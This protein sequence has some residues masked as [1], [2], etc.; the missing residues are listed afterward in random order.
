MLAQG[1]ALAVAL[2]AA[3]V[4]LHAGLGER[5][6]GGTQAGAGVG[7]E[8]LLHEGVQCALQIAQRDAF[9]HDQTFHLVEHGAVSSVRVRAEHAAGDQHLDGRLLA[10][11]SADL[12]TGG[13]SAQQELIRQIEG[14]LHIAGGVILGHVQAGEVVVVVLDLRGIR[15]GKAHTGEHVDDLVGDQ[16]QRVQTAHRAGLGRQRDIHRLR[17]I[18][19]SKFC[20]LHLFCSSVVICLNL[21]LEFIDDLAHSG[22]LF[23]RNGAQVLHQ[24]RDLAVFAEVLLPEGGQRFLAGHLTK[25]FSGLFCQLV[26]HCLHGCSLLYSS[27]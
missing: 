16:R 22:A 27:C 5:E 24:G 1:A 25:A 19:G 15:H 17:S 13:L 20:L 7:T 3:H 8:Q 26:D 9:I 14:I 18:A 12:T 21:C 11:H 10:V 23:R 2:E 6:V 4:H